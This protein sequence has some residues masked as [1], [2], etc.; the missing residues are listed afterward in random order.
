MRSIYF[1]EYVN[2]IN[3]INSFFTAQEQCITCFNE[4]HGM[5][6]GFDNHSALLPTTCSNY[7]KDNDVIIDLGCE[8]CGV[9]KRGKCYLKNSRCLFLDTSKHHNIFQLMCL[10]K[11]KK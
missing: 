3:Y 4:H 1:D 2:G 10:S 6:Q 7:I 8:S 11:V 9:Y 5:C